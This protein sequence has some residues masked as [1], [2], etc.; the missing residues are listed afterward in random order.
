MNHPIRFA[1]CLLFASI[2]HALACGGT[3]ETSDQT[4][5][6]SGGAG[7]SAGSGGTPSKGGNPGSGGS[8]TPLPCPYPGWDPQTCACMSLDAGASQDGSADAAQPLL[9]MTIETADMWLNCMPDIP[10]DPLGGT[11]TVR[12]DNSLGTSAASASILTVEWTLPGTYTFEVQPKDSGIIPAGKIV[13]V[14]HTKVANS[15]LPSGNPCSV[16]N[17]VGALHVTWDVSGQ[18]VSTDLVGSPGCAL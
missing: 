10:P 15:G 12:Y 8:C 11:F 7:A 3:V 5:G 13:D 1:T 17:G 14:V 2:A 9:K 4:T 16:C 18:S 6:G